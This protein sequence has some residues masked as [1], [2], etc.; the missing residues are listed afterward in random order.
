MIFIINNNIK[1]FFF[2][3]MF[4][5]ITL[6]ACEVHYGCIDENAVNFDSNATEDDGSCNY[7]ICLKTDND[8][9]EIKKN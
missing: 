5:L 4:I 1:K 3:T 6:S 2:L 8:C 9:L 7:N